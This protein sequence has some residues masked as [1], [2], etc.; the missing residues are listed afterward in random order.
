MLWEAKY[1]LLGKT[2]PH[3]CTIK[4]KKHN[5]N[6]LCHMLYAHQCLFTLLYAQICKPHLYYIYKHHC[7]RITNYGRLVND[8]YYGCLKEF[9]MLRRVNDL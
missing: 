8:M 7:V 3:A 4:S 5:K 1:K 9:S 2:V 6:Q